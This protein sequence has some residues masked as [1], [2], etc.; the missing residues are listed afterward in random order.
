MLD[1]DLDGLLSLDE[2]FS[3]LA[4]LEGPTYSAKAVHRVFDILDT[5]Q[6][7][8]ITPSKFREGYVRYRALRLALGLHKPSMDRNQPPG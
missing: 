4:G 1:L 2:V 6:D 5:N 8:K 3:H 7:G